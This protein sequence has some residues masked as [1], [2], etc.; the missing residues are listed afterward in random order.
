MRRW[1][2]CT[3]LAILVALVMIAPPVSAGQPPRS[4]PRASDKLLSSVGQRLTQPLAPLQSPGASGLTL[5]E[6]HGWLPIDAAVLARAKAAAAAAAGRS[7][8]SIHAS[9]ASRTI[10]DGAGTTYSVTTAKTSGKAQ[11]VS[12]SVTGLPAGATGTFSPVSVTAGG[13]STLSVTAGAS[14]PSGSFTL[15]ITGTGTTATHSTTVGLVVTATPPVDDFSIS[16]APSSQTVVQGAGTSYTVTTALTSGAAQTVSLSAAGLP[17]GTTGTFSPVSVSAGGISTLSVTAAASTPSGSF[18]LTITGTGA[19]ATHSTTVGLVVTAA[20]AGG[21]TLGLSWNGQSQGGLAPPD[22]TGAIGPRSYVELINL[23]Y[24]IYDRQN[25]ASPGVP[26]LL[27]QGDLGQLTGFPVSELSDPQILWD[28][29]SQ[30]FYYLVLDTS[31]DTFA[32][33]YSTGANPISGADFCKYIVDFGYG[34]TFSLPDYPKLGVTR[35]FVLIGANVFNLFGQYTGSDVDWFVK[36]SASPCPGTLGAGGLFKGVKNTDGKFT[37]TPV[38]SVSA[39]PT[40]TG[41]VVGSVDVGVGSGSMLTVFAVTKNVSGNA[42]ISPPNAI[43]VTSYSVPP[44]APQPGTGATI[45]TLDTRLKHAVA[46]VDPTLGGPAIWTAHTVFGGAGAEERWYEI[47]V[48]GTPSLVQA[49]KASSASLYVFNGGISPDRA[50]DGQTGAYGSDMVLGFNT[51][52]TAQYP[53]VQMVSKQGSN[54]QSGFVVV[55]QSL[56]AN[57]DFSCGPTC[58][59]GD[60]SGATPDPLASAGGQVWLSGEWNLPAT[61]G[62]ATVWQTW[63]WAAKP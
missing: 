5:H 9:P 57:V 10:A 1:K 29:S 33:G 8:F 32:F 49:G 11:T 19:S 25:L 7:D 28:P 14:T 63:N 61:D 43:P 4:N 13:S 18:T 37:S 20:Q 17:A 27:D 46:G 21:P 53:A 16:A 12:L 40:S 3:S 39:D 31:R 58:R 56:G 54:A 22:P 24:G 62:N 41:W 26:A 23:R 45:D 59:W 44:S 35:D 51:S 50:N 38:P 30:R 2:F 34:Q 48:G 52:S 60:Y 42:V 15:T 36:P 55:Q 6:G 47:G